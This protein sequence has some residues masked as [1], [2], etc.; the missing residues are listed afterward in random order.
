MASA[1]GVFA[2]EGARVE[3]YYIERIVT[4]DGQVVYE[5]ETT[6]EQVISRSTA[7]QVNTVLSANVLS[8]TGTAARQADGRQVAG[9]TGTAQNFED[10]WFAGYTADIAG[11][12]WMGNAEAKVAMVGVGGLR[13]VTGG[14]FPAQIWGKF[15]A[16]YHEGLPARPLCNAP[17]PPPFVPTPA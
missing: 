5:H 6:S 13:G 7:C 10:A 14:S 2:N 1:Y 16:A 17:L 9:K 11:A 15:V 4:S 12:I 3:P 8:G